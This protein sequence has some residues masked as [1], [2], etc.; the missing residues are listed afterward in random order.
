MARKPQ[1]GPEHLYQIATYLARPETETEIHAELHPNVKSA[2]EDEYAAATKNYPLPNRADH[3]PYYVWPPDVNKFGLQLRIY[4]FR[5]PPEPVPIQRLYTDKNKWR[6][7]YRI[8]HSNLVMQLFECGFVFR[9]EQS[10]QQ[11]DSRVHA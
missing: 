8:N 1:V 4:F 6:G 11:P 3:E 5:V 7:G 10:Q 9:Q 2:F